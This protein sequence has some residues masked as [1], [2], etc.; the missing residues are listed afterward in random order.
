MACLLF[1]MPQ[2][3][4][5]TYGAV[6]SDGGTAD[7]QLQG[8]VL[9][10]NMSVTVVVYDGKDGTLLENA[11]VALDSW[12]N[13]ALTN[14][15]GK[16]TLTGLV[17]Q[18][19]YDVYVGC[20]GYESEIVEYTCIED[21]VEIE[22]LD[23]QEKTVNIINILPRMN[24]LIRPAVANIDQAL[25]VF[26]VTEPKPHFNLLDRFLVM[27]ESKEIP[28]IL[29][30]N[31]KDIAKKQE[32]AEL[33][34][35]YRACGYPLILISA[36]EEENIEEIKKVLR[37]KT[38]TVA[39][40]SGVG[41]SSLINLLQSDIQ[42]ETGSISKKIARGKHTTRHSELITIDDNSYIM[43][44]PGFSSLYVNEFEKEELKYYFREFAPYEG[45]CRFNGCDHVHEP[46]CAVKDAVEE[47]KIH[48]I[49]YEDYLEMYQELKNK[50]RY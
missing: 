6:E 19:K 40:P 8:K 25:V 28:A 32:V 39:G 47:G 13:Y 45:Q 9:K 50:K 46:G 26:A 14:K 10:N 3:Q 27:M 11:T 23:E 4:A 12:S 20:G 16:V 49:R 41:K 44:T 17:E 36:K 38:T 1:Q 7:I 15:T 22:V 5:L 33:E 21:N 35:V 34:E 18:Q 42:M 37:G 43:D 48:K 31:K 29:C 2:M 24:E 30:F